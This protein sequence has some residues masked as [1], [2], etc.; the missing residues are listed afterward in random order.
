MTLKIAKNWAWVIA[1]FIPLALF[2]VGIKN[3]IQV[4]SFVGG[5]MLGID[6]ILILLM[7]RKIKTGVLRN[8]TYPLI[9]VLII[10]IIYEIIYFV[11]AVRPNIEHSTIIK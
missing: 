11:G 10:G 1:C 3:F 9:L 5:I 8:L 7:Y 4:I 2:L 6:G